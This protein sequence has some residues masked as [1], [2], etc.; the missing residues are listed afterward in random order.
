MIRNESL[1]IIGAGGHGK[2]VADIAKKT[3]LYKHIA[4]LD[5][6]LNKAVPGYKWL[7]KPEE[8]R[9]WAKH[10]DFFVAIGDG[11]GRYKIQK[12]LEGEVILA[13]LIH[14]SAVIAEDVKIGNGTVIMANAVVNSGSVLGC[15]VIINTAS[16]VDHDCKIGNYVHIAPGCHICGTVSVGTGTWIG[17]GAC[18]ING[19]TICGECT[20][21]AGAAVICDI[22]ENGTYVGIPAKKQELKSP[23]LDR[24]KEKTK[25]EV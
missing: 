11:Q 25:Q 2:V 17:V 8:Y 3:K 22:T 12:E 7:G 1:I 20:I 24:R 10:S 23:S 9:K 6:N 5:E 19:I 16:T 14:P 13:T 21:G 18:V 15:G 4:F